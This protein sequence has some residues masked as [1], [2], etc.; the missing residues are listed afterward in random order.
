MITIKIGIKDINL[1]TPCK[2]DKAPTEKVGAAYNRNIL[3]PN[4]LFRIL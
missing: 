4:I 3:N 2:V 1:E